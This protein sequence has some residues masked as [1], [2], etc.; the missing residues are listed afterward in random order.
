MVLLFELVEEVLEF[1]GFLLEEGDLLVFGGKVFLDELGALAENV[2]LGCVLSE[3]E[4]ELHDIAVLFVVVFFE[5]RHIFLS[6]Q[7]NAVLLI[8]F[9]P[10]AFELNF[11]PPVLAFEILQRVPGGF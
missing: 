10:A 11:E 5:L 6:V 2:V 4:L 9:D 8:E 1:V 7:V 3:F